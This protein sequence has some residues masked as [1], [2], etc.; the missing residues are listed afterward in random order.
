MV[1]RTN[2][3]L[4]EELVREAKERTGVKT[5]REVLDMALRE[6]VRLGRQKSIRRLRGKVD[7]VGDLDEMRQSRFDE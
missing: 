3:V 6:F 2:V 5:T 4:D 7:W 1:K